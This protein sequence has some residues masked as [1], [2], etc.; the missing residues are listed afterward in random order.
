VKLIHENNW[1]ARLVLAGGFNAFMFFGLVLAKK[2]LSGPGKRH[3]MTHVYQ[4]WEVTYSSLLVAGVTGLFTGAWWTVALSPVM[5][6]AI[7]GLNWLGSR[8]VPKVGNEYRAIGFEREARYF[9]GDEGYLEGRPPFAW[10][11]WIFT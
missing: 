8:C 7:Y 11:R 2:T 6:Y 1:F 5:F 4:W 10:V 3:E 9:E